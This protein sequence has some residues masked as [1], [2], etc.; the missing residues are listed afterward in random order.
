MTQKN[1]RK[2]FG[3]ETVYH[4]QQLEEILPLLVFVR[5]VLRQMPAVVTLIPCC[6]MKS[7]R[8]D[9]GVSK[10]HGE[11]RTK[12]KYRRAYEITS[13]WAYNTAVRACFLTRWWHPTWKA[14]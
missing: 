9:S 13:K 6:D 14:D 10:I 3:T 7:G 12:Q 8:G 4:L 1:C 5:A 2:R 11:G